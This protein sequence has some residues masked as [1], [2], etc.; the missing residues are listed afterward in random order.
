MVERTFKFNIGDAEL[1]DLDILIDNIFYEIKRRESIGQ[2]YAGMR[3]IHDKFEYKI[4][5]DFMR[6]AKR[7][8]E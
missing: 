2:R 4:V 1:S 7:E 3:V 8:I 6:I 5:L